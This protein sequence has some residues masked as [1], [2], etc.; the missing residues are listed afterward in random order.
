MR[1][2]VEQFQ[3]RLARLYPELMRS[4]TET[5]NGKPIHALSM[6]VTFQITDA[7]NL[8]CSYCYQIN[9]GH[10]V[11][12]LETAK[13]AIDLIMSGEK[14]FHEYINP[15]KSPGIILE[16][17][18]GEP[19]L[20]VDLIDQIIDYFREKAVENYSQWANLFMVSI[21]SNGTLYN[22]PKVQRFLKKHRQHLSFSVTLD[23]NKELHDSCRVFPDGSGS[24]DLAYSAIKDWM[25]KGYYMGSKITLAPANVSYTFDASKHMFEM[26]YD[27]ININCVYEEGWTLDHAKIL[28]DQL[29]MVADYM[30]ENDYED[31]YYAMFDEA[32]FKPKDPEDV[33]NWCGGDA[34]MLAIDP[35]GKL[36][37]CLRYM[38][39]SLGGQQEPMVIGDVDNGMMMRPE[40]RKRVECLRCITRRTQSTD[41]CFNCPIA[42]GCS[43]C[44]AYNYQ[45]FGTA[46]HRATYI[47][48][49]HK[50]RSLANVYFWNLY[51]RKHGEDKHFEM[52][53]PK[54]WAVPIIGEEEYNMLLELS[55]GN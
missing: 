7:C 28:Y 15:E 29:K 23:G 25:S 5:I 3:D 22:E 27:E 6:P 55:G 42:E 37:P 54:D 1:R 51:Y 4:K 45:T 52:H 16:F 50:A 46:D 20:Q 21:C 18:G 35:D 39:S 14:G 17:I 9:K 31:Y 8:C 43:W 32:F 53:C 47:C 24:Y 44:S 34:S 33:Q 41:E 2:H 10:R 12:S 19:F 36:Y 49:M 48:P 30:L 26:G 38:E 11:M 40:E 13:K